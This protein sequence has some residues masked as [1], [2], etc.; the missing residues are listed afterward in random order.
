MNVHQ[1]FV[2]LTLAISSVACQ[3]EEACVIP[4]GNEVICTLQ[5]KSVCEQGKGHKFVGGDCPT[6][7]YAKKVADGVWE[8][9]Q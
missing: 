2:V 3:S 5:K 8:K 7:G 4:S 1:L 9:K 6:A